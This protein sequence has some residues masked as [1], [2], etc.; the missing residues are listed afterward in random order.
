MFPEGQRKRIKYEKRNSNT[1]GEFRPIGRNSSGRLL[2]PAART[3]RYRLISMARDSFYL[4]L[5]KTK[6][7]QRHLRA[8]TRG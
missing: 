4:I 1:L 5:S 7:I 2:K 8:Q 6:H 3:A